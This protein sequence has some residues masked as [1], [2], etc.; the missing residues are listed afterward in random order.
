[1]SL[2]LINRR[3]LTMEKFRINP[4]NKIGKFVTKDLWSDRYHKTIIKLTQLDEYFKYER[5]T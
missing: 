1:M 2:G 4:P 3:R 5:D